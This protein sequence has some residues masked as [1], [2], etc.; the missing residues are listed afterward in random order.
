MARAIS[1]RAALTGSSGGYE[2]TGSG[3]DIASHR[4]SPRERLSGCRHPMLAWERIQR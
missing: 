2:I 4:M 1:S 3:A